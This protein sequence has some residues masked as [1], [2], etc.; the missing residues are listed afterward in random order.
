MIRMRPRGGLSRR[1]AAP[2]CVRA[3]P[4]SPRSGDAQDRLPGALTLSPIV[5]KGGRLVQPTHERSA[6]FLAE[7]AAGPGG[8][9]TGR[10]LQLGN[11]QNARE[12]VELIAHLYGRSATA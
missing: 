6:G 2:G 5:R 12:R 3:E 1:V 4:L 7:G 9:A 8:N 10:Q 11:R